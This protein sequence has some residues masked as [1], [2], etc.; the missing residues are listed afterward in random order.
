MKKRIQIDSALLSFLVILTG[1]LYLNKG[2]YL[3]SRFWDNVLDFFGIIAV[4]K[5]TLLRM[6]ARGHK[7]ANSARGESLVMTGPYTLVRNPMYLGSFLMGVGFILIVWPWWGLPIF[8]VLFYLRFNQQIVKEEEHLS[9]VF[10][11]DYAA[12]CQKT[13]RLFP[14]LKM[15]KNIR[16]KEVLNVKEALSTKEKRALLGWPLLAV[17]LETFQESIVFGGSDFVHTVHIF[18]GA[19]ILFSI[20]LWMVHHYG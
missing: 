3:T 13:P 8:A 7:K 1:F 6:M 14:S 12:Y 20:G 2:L 16:I 15:V 18:V 5:G 10:G 17:V 11:A 19:I 9:Q 4:L